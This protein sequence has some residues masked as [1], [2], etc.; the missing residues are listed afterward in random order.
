MRPAYLAAAGIGAGLVAWWWFGRERFD[1]VDEIGDAVVELTTSDEARLAQLEPGTQQVV[2]QLI[3]DLAAAGVRVKVGQTLRTSAQE[4][5]AIDA[6]RSAVKSHSW[7][8]IGRAVDLYPIDPATGSA[9]LNGSNVELFRQMHDAAAALGLRGLA[10]NDDGSKR[11][12][13]N[14]AGKKIWDGG[15]LEWRQPYGSI[16]EAVSA[17]GAAYGI[18]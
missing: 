3:A 11:Y 17:E 12:I 13:V 5:A 14:S 4:K 8:E 1:L 9:D 15:H 16:A 2:R 6:G 10:F 7:H 18:A